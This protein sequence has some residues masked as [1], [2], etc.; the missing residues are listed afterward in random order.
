MS[1]N[2]LFQ[3]I[4]NKYLIFLINFFFNFIIFIQKYVYKPLIYYVL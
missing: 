4:K 3:V 2:I 1:I